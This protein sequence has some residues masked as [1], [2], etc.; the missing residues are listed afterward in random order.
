MPEQVIEPDK[1]KR[2]GGAR[3]THMFVD[4]AGCEIKLGKTPKVFRDLLKVHNGVETPAPEEGLP[5][6]TLLNL[7][8]PVNGRLLEPSEENPVCVKCEMFTHNCRNPFLPPAGNPKPLVTFVLD[9]VSFEEDTHGYIGAAGTSKLLSKLVDAM[10]ERTGVTSDDCRFV[11]LTRCSHRLRKAVNYKSKGEHCK[12]YAVQDLHAHQPQLIIPVGTAALGLLCHKSNAQDWGGRLLTWR[13]WP[14]N[15][16]T[17]ADYVKPRQLVVDGVPRE[18]TGHPVLGPAPGPDK[19]CMLYP[20][21]SPRLI[22]MMQ[23]QLVEDRWKLQLI[24]GLKLAVSG[25][26]PLVYNLPHYRLLYTREEV[27]TEMLKISTRPGLEVCYDTE[28]TGVLPFSGDQLVFMMFRYIDPDTAQPVAIGFPWNY[29]EDSERGPASPLLPYLDELKPYVEAALAASILV[30][31]NLTFDALFAYCGLSKVSDFTAL[32]ADG[33][34]RDEWRRAMRRLNAITEASRYD[35]WHMAYTRK[36][37]RGSLG[38]EILAYDFVPELAGYEEELTLLIELEHSRM[39]PEAGGHYARCPEALWETHFKPYVLG[40]VEV[41]HRAKGVLQ[42]R[43]ETSKQYRVPVAHTTKRGM[44]RYFQPPGREWLYRSVMSP[45]SQV[46]AKMMGR[47]M[48]IDGQVLARLEDAMPKAIKDTVVAMRG[49]ES[50]QIQAWCTEQKATHKKSEDE[51]KEAT[52][53]GKKPPKEVSDWELD[54]DKKDHLRA[55]LFDVLKLPVQRLTK[56]GRLLYGEEPDQWEHRIRMAL[57]PTLQGAYPTVVND[58]VRAELLKYAALDKFTLNRLSVDHEQVRPLQNY[59]KVHKLYSTYVRPLRNIFSAGVDKK[60]RV[61]APHLCPDHMIHAQFMLTGTRG[62]RLSCRNPNLQQLPKEGYRSGI[63]EYNVKEMYVSRFGAR[64]CL[65][66][67]DFSQ[68]ELRL[69]AA[70]SGDPSMVEAYFKDIDL[71][72]LTASR[73]F[74]LSYDTFSKDHFKW[75]EANGRGNEAKDL[76]LKRDIG[77]TV[78][79]LTGYGGGA[80]G[81]QTVLAGRQLYWQLEQCEELINTFFESYPAV[82]DLLGYYKRFIYDNRVAVSLFGRV[83]VFEEV[84]SG[85]SEIASK[86]LRAGCNHLIQSTA[87]DMMLVCL[88]IIEDLMRKDNLDSI[89]ISTVHDSLVID[90]V[91]DELPQVHDIVDTVLNNMPDFFRAYLGDDF[92]L[93]WMLVPFAGDSDVGLNYAS[94]RGVPKSGAIDWDELLA[95]G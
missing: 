60:E 94:M 22:Y 6:Y 28:T 64:G 74:K 24:R 92:D 85:D 9:S 58:A 57:E 46:L 44:F 95:K 83:R 61:K 89:L 40:D 81:L 35:T 82:R 90:A 21:Q 2:R 20:I 30:G 50:S 80:F 41:C 55:I 47:G 14:D 88:S 36:Q 23:N 37:E 65:Y 16:L 70:V 93:S 19:R 76:K 68:I 63:Y 17:D 43:L 3:K 32:D 69:L 49:D 53:Q 52:P 67:A 91:R 5:P 56:S 8:D 15:W 45:A 25:A 59:R 71:H 72:T 34:I 29:D 42:E 38:L 39:H 27:I 10:A 66:G 48:F 13:G 73:L 33:N 51:A 18:V 84:R 12:I 79:F 7:A 77:K 4:S 78:N 26:Q 1:K 62:G 87:S 86:A 31:H 75:L 54:L 11:T